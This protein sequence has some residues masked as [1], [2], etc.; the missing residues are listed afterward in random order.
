[1]TSSGAILHLPFSVPAP[2][3]GLPPLL[4]TIGFQMATHLSPIFPGEFPVPFLPLPTRR[5]FFLVFSSPS[6]GTSLESSPRYIVRQISRVPSFLWLIFPC[7]NRFVFTTAL[8][9]R[10]SILLSLIFLPLFPSTK[11]LPI[12]PFPFFFS[13]LFSVFGE[14]G[15][16]SVRRGLSSPILFFPETSYFN[17][18]CPR[19]DTPFF[20]A[21][22]CGH[23]RSLEKSFIMAPPSFPTLPRNLLSSLVFFSL[24]FCLEELAVSFSIFFPLSPLAG[25]PKK[26]DRPI[27]FSLN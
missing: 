19:S 22:L 9:P 3:P 6:T 10:H 16:E 5:R 15:R 4:K 21:W 18:E 7:H 14:R 20:S 13:I 24:A 8:P 2:F 1:M 23:A 12:D 17:F 27:C 11:A 25:S 26:L